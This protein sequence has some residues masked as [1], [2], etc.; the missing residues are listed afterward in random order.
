MV[1]HA[2]RAKVEFSVIDK[3]VRRSS[4]SFGFRQECSVF[5]K[6]IEYVRASIFYDRVV[7]L[8]D[9]AGHK[10]L[11]IVITRVNIYHKAS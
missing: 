7:Q 1:F 2:V 6:S 9:I 3:N 8:N 11:L 10:K 5:S 4:R